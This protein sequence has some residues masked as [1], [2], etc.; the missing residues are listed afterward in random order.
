MRLGRT[1]ERVRSIIGRVDGPPPLAPP[2]KGEGNGEPDRAAASGAEAN[3]PQ[4]KNQ[5]CVD[6]AACALD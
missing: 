4:I 5:T 3:Y 1:K 6:R 2:R